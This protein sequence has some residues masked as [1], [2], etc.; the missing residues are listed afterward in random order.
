MRYWGI[1]GCFL[2]NDQKAGFQCLTDESHEVRAMAAWLM[3]RTGEKE[4]GTQCLG[5]LLKSGSYATLSILNIIDWMGDDGKA[6]MPV[7]QSLKLTN[8]EAAMQENLL[9]KFGLQQKKKVKRELS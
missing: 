4:K 3:V 9:L 7:V 8:H 5:N 2:L 6:L 1:V